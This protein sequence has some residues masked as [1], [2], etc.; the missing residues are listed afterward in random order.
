MKSICKFYN[1][2]IL[3]I[4]LCSTTAFA[5]GPSVESDALQVGNLVFISGQ[6]GGD[7][8]QPD[9]TGEAIEESLKKIEAVAHQMGGDL[10]DIIKLNIYT[11]NLD[12]DFSFINQMTT[13]YFSAPYPT[14]TTV[15]VAKIPKNHTVEIDAIMVLRNQ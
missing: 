2:I 13:K 3:A 14:R 5:D 8:G 7:I 11:S 4:I 15:G 9:N 6:G 10:S 1:L 12:R